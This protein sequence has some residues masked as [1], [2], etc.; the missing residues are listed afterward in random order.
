MQNQSNDDWV[1]KEET[2]KNH[3]EAELAPWGDAVRILGDGIDL[4]GGTFDPA[5][6]SPPGYAPVRWSIDDGKATAAV[7]VDRR[8]HA[9][10]L[11]RRVTTPADDGRRLAGGGRPAGGNANVK[12]LT[13][14]R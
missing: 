3:W 1:I 5:T 7:N 4:G 11:D 14:T 13:F 6:G 9:D 8:R 2:A 10:R 12:R